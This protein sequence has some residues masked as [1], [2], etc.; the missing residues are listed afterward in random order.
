[1]LRMVEPL[2]TLIEAS[3]AIMPDLTIEPTEAL[4]EPM[5][6]SLPAAAMP[7]QNGVKHT[8]RDNKSR[9]AFESLAMLQR[10]VL[11]SLQQRD[12]NDFDSE[13][14]PWP[15]KFSNRI[16]AHIVETQEEQEQTSEPAVS[17]STM[18][19]SPRSRSGSRSRGSPRSR[20][21]S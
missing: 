13:M 3:D 16:Q 14:E 21:A 17:R 6:Q 12:T 20:E 10:G 15:S 18:M 8:N 5:R 9:P 7:M 19:T 1:M 4:H 2:T 11:D